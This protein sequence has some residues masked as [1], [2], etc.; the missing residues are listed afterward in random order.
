M[1]S[2]ARR[3]IELLVIA[4]RENLM[5]EVDFLSVLCFFNGGAGEQ[6]S[7]FSVGRSDAWKRSVSIN[8]YL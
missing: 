6:L 2:N 5:S 1:T 3:K 8:W 4:I 7:S